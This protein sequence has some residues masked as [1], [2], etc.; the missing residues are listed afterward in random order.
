MTLET[1]ADEGKEGEGKANEETETPASPVQSDS[2]EDFLLTQYMKVK[3]EEIPDSEEERE[4]K[5]EEAKRRRAEQR[6]SSKKKRQKVGS[7][8]NDSDDEDNDMNDEPTKKRQG[9][10]KARV[11]TT[12]SSK[13]GED[14]DDESVEVDGGQSFDEIET[15]QDEE[16]DPYFLSLLESAGDGAELRLSFDSVLDTILGHPVYIELNA[17]PDFSAESVASQLATMREKIGSGRYRSKQT[18]IGDVRYMLSQLVKNKKGEPLAM[19]NKI[20]AFFDRY[21]PD[22]M[23]GP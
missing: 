18:F 23:E 13:D 16:D 14:A 10:K 20:A 22:H 12:S 1:K 4:K 11:V 7:G 5:K 19:Q 2:E 3:W 15:E 6:A 17:S 9:K 8:A 21:I